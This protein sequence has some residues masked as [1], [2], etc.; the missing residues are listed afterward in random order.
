MADSNEFI[1]PGETIAISRAVHLARLAAYYGPCATCNRRH[2][3]GSGFVDPPVSRLTHLSGSSERPAS[4][5]ADGIELQADGVRAAYQN[6]ITRQVA[7]RW[8]FQFGQLV[9][10]EQNR[11]EVES[12]SVVVGY[13]ERPE[14][15]EIAAGIA[16]G[17]MIACLDV[18]D[19][20]RVTKPAWRA[21]VSEQQAAGG[22][23]ITGS[24]RGPLATGFDFCEADGVPWS[25]LQ[26]I[27]DSIEHVNLEQRPSRASGNVRH[28]IGQQQYLDSLKL[29]YHAIRPL[30]IVFASS[31]NSLLDTARLVFAGLPCELIV[32]QL[33]VR[34]RRLSDAT[35]ADVARVGEI[36]RQQEGSLG[37]IVDP[38]GERAGLITER[39]EPATAVGLA[40]L[41]VMVS[42]LNSPLS[43]VVVESALLPHLST[44][45][46][47]L[48]G[49]CLDG[50]KGPN[51]IV[52]TMRRVEANLGLLVDHRCWLVGATPICDAL[53]TLGIVAQGLSLKDW[54]CSQAILG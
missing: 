52:T 26:E 49:R 17:L 48:G 14:S 30:K 46:F 22:V 50:G 37:W 24:G 44:Q 15:P 16:Q 27:A 7:V 25:S 21:V 43:P 13:D 23:L 35:D 51:E 18:L 33:P 20:G 41:L 36:V 2:E 8:G 40:R 9:W 5:R 32:E 53:A 1:C 34:H 54:T 39:G 4:I 29:W 3:T 12:R 47:D 6:V 19:I 42:L 11:S 10:K 38:D 45:I 31:D 28:L